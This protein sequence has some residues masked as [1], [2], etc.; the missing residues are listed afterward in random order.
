MITPTAAAQRRRWQPANLPLVVARP[1]ARQRGCPRRRQQ[2]QPSR[3]DLPRTYVA[4]LIG[5]TTAASTAL[6]PAL[7]LTTA[8]T[9]APTAN[10]G[11]DQKGPLGSLVTS[12]VKRPRDPE[13][14]GLY[15]HYIADRVCRQQSQPTGSNTVHPAFIADRS[16]NYIAQLIVSDGALASA[17]DCL[18]PSTVNS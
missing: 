18:P 15:S 5:G 13:G 3:P 9:A 12:T 7:P 2:R 8:N 10:A 14:A 1:P 17:P 4:Q 6:P 11:P 16:G